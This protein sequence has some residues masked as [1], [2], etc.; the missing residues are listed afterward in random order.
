MLIE[1]EL[2]EKKI[3]KDYGLFTFKLYGDLENPEAGQFV[4]LKASDEPVLAK[5]F[6][7]YSYKNRE[8]TLF[9]KRVGRLTGKIFS[10]PIGEMF[11][12]R[13]PHGNPYVDLIDGEKQYILVGGGSC[14]LYTSPSPRDS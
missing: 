8:L 7:I 10:S 11:Y 9:I 1:A 4:M 6:S 14:L 12:I 13:G 2:K 3:S 5:P